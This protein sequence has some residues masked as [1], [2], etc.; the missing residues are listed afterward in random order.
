M[1]QPQYDAQGKQVM[2]PLY[3]A[4]VGGVPGM[5][6]NYAG[7]AIESQYWAETSC[8][9]C[10]SCYCIVIQV[11]NIIG[12]LLGSFVWASFGVLGI[13]S[14]LRMFLAFF[15]L[16][17]YIKFN[18]AIMEKSITSWGSVSTL[19][20]VWASI[21]ILCTIIAFVSPSS[22][23]NVIMMIWRKIQE[24]SSTSSYYGGYSSSEYRKIHADVATA[25]YA[26]SAIATL[27][28]LIIDLILI[29]ILYNWSKTFANLLTQ[30]KA[31]GAYIGN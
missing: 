8:S 23:A 30:A 13:E 14:I 12:V 24:A 25:V 5:P 6:T 29:G 28:P 26:T 16:Y 10:W 18:G 20:I 7:A 15:V 2:Q 3:M 1:M 11:F 22:T 9:K 19:L 17:T 21:D 27:I 31:N 4:P